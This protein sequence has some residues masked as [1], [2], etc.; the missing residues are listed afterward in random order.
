MCK[1]KLKDPMLPTHTHTHSFNGPFSGTTQVS[2][3][4]KGKTNLDFTWEV[5]GQETQTQQTV[6][7]RCSRSALLLQNPYNLQKVANVPQKSPFSWRY[8]LYPI[9]DSLA[10]Y[11][12]EIPPYVTSVGNGH[13]C[14]LWIM[15]SK[16][17]SFLWPS[18]LWNVD[19][20]VVVVMISLCI[21]FHD[22]GFVCA[23][24]SRKTQRN[25]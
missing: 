25:L 17:R 15:Q 12:S 24:T 13:I 10:Q 23:K 19:K 4:Q 8:R 6:N 11:K 21:K 18:P 9:Q 2:R 5:F 1:P 22:S 3:Y 20:S 7:V 16:N 14:I